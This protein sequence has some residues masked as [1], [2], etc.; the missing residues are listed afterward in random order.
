MLFILF[1]WLL[2]VRLCLFGWLL[3]LFALMFVFFCFLFVCYCVCGSGCWLLVVY[4]LDVL[5][6][7]E[8]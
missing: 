3:W 6:F 7:V 1:V 2:L 8:L 4:G 5:D